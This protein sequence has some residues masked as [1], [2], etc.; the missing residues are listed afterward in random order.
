M[1]RW[2]LMILVVLLLTGCGTEP[3]ET[4]PAT[5]PPPTTAPT[6]PEPIPVG[7]YDP[8]SSLEASTNGAIQ[9]YP[10]NRTD[11]YGL[12]SMGS[13]LL[14]LSG[15]EVT[16]LTRLTG[17]NLYVAA[18]AN[19]GMYI[20]V[21]SPAFHASDKGITFYDAS[22]QQLVFLDADL[23]EVSRF[24]LPEHIQGEPAL[25]A[26]RKNLYYLT[27]ESLRSI[28]LETGLDKLIRQLSSQAHV[29]SALHCGDSIL[30]CRIQDGQSA[31]SSLFLSV[32]TGETVLEYRDTVTLETSGNTYFAVHEDGDFTEFLVGTGTQAP[33]LLLADS[34]GLSAK[35][36]L[37]QNGAVVYS[38]SDTR[39]SLDY[40]EL[41]SGKRISA[42]ELPATIT[43]WGIQGS[44]QENCIWFMDYDETSGSD[45]LYRWNIDQTAVADN[46]STLVQRYTAASPDTAGL[47]A[48]QERANL[49]AEKSR[50]DIQIWHSASGF[51]PEGW[52]LTAEHHTSIIDRHLPVI[53]QALAKY[54][55]G[56]LEKAASGGTLQIYL[57]RSATAVTSD[58]AGL[59]TWDNHGNP[60]VVVAMDSRLEQNLYHSL[61]HVIDSYVLSHCSAYDT[62]EQLN[63]AGFSYT[64]NYS[65]QIED[66]AAFFESSDVAFIDPFSMTY[67]R[68]DRARIMEYAMTPGNEAYFA[69]DT[70]QL[71]LRTLCHGIRD[72]FRLK[73]ATASF[74]W[75]QYLLG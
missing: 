53:D 66:P 47:A 26:D 22:H 43:P 34:Y 38:C 5:Q 74:P 52:E 65:T 39:L 49:I 42:V 57:V 36:V 2:L 20:D 37:N 19:L 63:P 3:V 71:K 1:K 72:A 8:D 6:A 11:S 54:P 61:F 27:G 31:Q 21:D 32:S 12:V 67:P 69:S 60:C 24:S 23:K 16:T 28:D 51:Q 44:S 10:L 62:W 75:E 58:P 68:E 64:Y 4:I 7:Y 15:N 73:K 33:S 41:D 59:Q 55:E 29:I 46:G 25:S 13:S 48:C 30:Q 9:V 45:T 56:F 18:A 70:M 14:L 17:S 35:A 40:F 50:I